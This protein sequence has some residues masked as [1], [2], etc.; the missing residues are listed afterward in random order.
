MIS[1][2]VPGLT[3]VPVD[4]LLGPVSRPEEPSTPAMVLHRPD[5][6][7]FVGAGSLAGLEGDARR[8]M[9][10]QAGSHDAAGFLPPPSGARARVVYARG[11]G[12]VRGSGLDVR[13]SLHKVLVVVLSTS[14]FFNLTQLFLPADAA[15]V[16]MAG[17]KNLRFEYAGVSDPALRRRAWDLSSVGSVGVLLKFGTNGSRD[18]QGRHQCVAV[19]ASWTPELGVSCACSEVE[20]CLKDG[21]VCS[22]REPM[23]DALKAVQ[24]ALGVT[25]QQLFSILSAS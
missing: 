21:A 8:R 17:L 22:M 11:T 15:G 12:R 7:S 9:K 23:V 2:S 4:A 16:D 6:L 14:A 5:G 25:M 3:L 13:K 19:E 24:A 1:T 10:Y 20:N 18:D